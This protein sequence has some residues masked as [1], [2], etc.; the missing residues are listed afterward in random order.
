MAN[1][2]RKAYNISNKLFIE[3]KKK[4]NKYFNSFKGKGRD[5]KEDYISTLLSQLI[6]LYFHYELSFPI[7]DDDVDFD[8][9]S[10]IIFN[11]EKMIDFINKGNNRKSRF[12]N[13]TVF[14]FKW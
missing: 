11:H 12:H 13:F 2:S 1:I 5:V 7:V 6:I 3:G 8:Y 10:D 14:I 9:N 4:Y